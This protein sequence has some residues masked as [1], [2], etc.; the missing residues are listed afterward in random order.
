MLY[1]YFDNVMQNNNL[2][3]IS[4]EIGTKI[5]FLDFDGVLNNSEYHTRLSKSGNPTSDKYGELFDPS[6]IER[7]NRIVDATG[8]QIVVSSS[9]RYLGLRQLKEMWK[10]RGLHGEII[11]MTSL[12]A[13]DD[14]IMEK[15][16]DWLENSAC[17]DDMP[18]PRSMEI[19]H[20]LQNKGCISPIKYVIL[21]DMPMP[22]QLQPHFVQVNPAYG[23]LEQQAER[24]IEILNA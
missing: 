10:A 20:W 4:A 15:G 14:I 2:N 3:K 17:G 9:W 24:A 22:T 1:V 18:T 11:D 16:L 6:A 7:L 12:H 8:A 5:I 13:V 19:T 23:L 21:D